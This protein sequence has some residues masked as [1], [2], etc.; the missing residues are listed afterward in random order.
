MIR[1][2]FVDKVAIILL[3]IGGFNAGLDGIF[4]FNLIELC[5]EDTFI[6]S[7]FYISLGLSAL[8]LSIFTLSKE[9]D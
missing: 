1:F 5:F 3:L 7:F 9:R 2:R 8:W 6:L 4:Q